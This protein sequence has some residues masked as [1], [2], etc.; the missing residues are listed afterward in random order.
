MRN[1]DQVFEQDPTDHDAGPLSEN[2]RVLGDLTEV[3]VGAG[4][5]DD[6]R[7]GRLQRRGGRSAQRC[8]KRKRRLRD[9]EHAHQTGPYLGVAFVYGAEEFNDDGVVK[10]SLGAAGFVG[11]RIIPHVAAELRYTAFDGFDIQ[12]SNGEAEVDG[13]AV[14]LNAKVYPI[15]TRIQPFVVLGVGGVHLESKTRLNDGRR[16]QGQESDAVFRF[17]AGGDLPLG[18]N[19]T[20]NLEAAYLAPTD[21]LSDFSIKE[22]ST[23][24]TYRF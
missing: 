19:L 20:L 23:G 18:E 10:S 5:R 16:F 24:L 2:A 9:R 15:T 17:G 21:D 6:H 13:Y 22:P 12:A 1:A 8:A 3:C 4:G 14:T 11:W 7:K